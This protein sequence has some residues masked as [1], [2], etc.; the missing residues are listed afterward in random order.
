M[1]RWY[2]AAVLTAGLW[3]VPGGAAA[4]D[5]TIGQQL[6]GF[7]LQGY[8]DEGE[9]SW[10]MKGDKADILGDK[11]KVSNVDANR[12]GD[13]AVNLKADKGLIDKA[14]GDVQLNDNVVITAESGTQLKTDSLTWE[15]SKDLVSTSDPVEISNEKSGMTATG[16]GL[17]AH[18]SLGT[19]QMNKDITAQVN[20]QPKEPQEGS[21]LTVTC[22]GPM[23]MD[24]KAS[25]ATFEQN[26]VAVQTDRTLKA[27]RVEIYFDPLTRK[28]REMVCIGN[29]LIQQGIN[30][31]HSDHAVYNAQTQK[32]VLSGKPKLTL[33]TQGQDGIVNLQP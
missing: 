14:N 27:D 15:K 10:D 30:T 22:D 5:V 20:T 1:R 25:L 18:P 7:N 8:T 21:V 29:V 2:L 9:K 23:V 4:Q 3:F 19:A 6:E 16:V 26:V 28:V 31:T 13:E 12:Y 33:T 24:E 11:I 32:M 17:T